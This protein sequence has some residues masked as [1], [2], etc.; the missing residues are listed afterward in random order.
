MF[1]LDVFQY[2]HQSKTIKQ[3]RLKKKTKKLQTILLFSS[4]KNTKTD[5][6]REFNC[7]SFLPTSTMFSP[8]AA[9]FRAKAFPTP[10]VGP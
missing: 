4:K 6:E 8:L 5:L 10:E 9:R 2:I 1:S 7:F 3:L